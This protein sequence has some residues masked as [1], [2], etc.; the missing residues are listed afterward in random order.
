MPQMDFIFTVLS[1]DQKFTSSVVF[2]SPL[3]II[4]A[5][6][7]HP[8]FLSMEKNSPVLGNKKVSQSVR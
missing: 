2:C 5:N 4:N 6:S 8:V 3:D 1:C 7:A